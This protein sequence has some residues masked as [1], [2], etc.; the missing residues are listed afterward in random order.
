MKNNVIAFLCFA[1]CLSFFFACKQESPQTQPLPEGIEA[2]L[3]AYTSGTVS[4]T[5]PVEVRFVS[6]AIDETQVGQEAPE[7]VIEFTPKLTGKTIWKNRQT[8]VFTPDP[9]MKSG[10][11]YVAKVALDKVMDNLPA[12]LKSFE[13]DF[14]TKDQGFRVEAG[15]PELESEETDLS[16]QMIVGK[17]ETNDFAEPELVEQLLEAKQNGAALR[18]EWTHKDGTQHIFSIRGIQRGK[19]PSSVTLSWDGAPLGLSETGQRVIEIPKL[20]DFKISNATVVNEGGQYLL[21]HFTDPLLQNQDLRGLISLSDYDGNLDFVIDGNRLRVYPNAKLAGEKKVTAKPG[22]KNIKGEKM[23]KPSVWTLT[24]TEPEPGVRLVRSG[25]IMP[26]SKG[27]VLPFEAVNLNAVVVE[28]FKVFN[29]NIL[30][31][32]QDNDLDGHYDL[33][34]VGRVILQEKIDLAKLN[35]GASAKT[36]THYALD[37]EKLIQTDPDAIYQIR[38]GFKPEFST[39]EC[40][41]GSFIGESEVTFPKINE[42]GEIESFWGGW[43][44]INGPYD[45]YRWQDRDDPCKP[46]YYNYE[47]FVRQNI[48]SSNIG[49]TAKGGLDGSY[50]VAV[51]NLLNAQPMEGAEVRFYDYQQQ[52]LKSTKTDRY[53]IAQVELSRAPFVCVAEKGGDKGFLKMLDGNALSLSRFDVSG[54]VA[55]KGLKGFIYGDRGVWRP[56]DS[57]FLHFVLQDKT[58]KIPPNHPITF[59]L[60][61]PR[62]QVREKR[63]VTENKDF[64]YP[65]HVGTHSDDPTGNWIANISVGGAKFRKVVKIETIKPNRLKIDLDFGSEMLLAKNEPFPAE[66]QVNWLHGAPAK[67]LRAVVEAQIKTTRTRFKNYDQ[68]VFDDPA[69]QVGDEPFKIFEGNLDENG[70]ASFKTKI[71]HNPNV[72]PGKLKVA[73]NTRA[74]EK[75]GDFSTRYSEI[76]YSPFPQYV[77]IAVPKNK[78]N[79]PQIDIGKDADI[80][81][82][83][84]DA[85]GKPVRNKNISVGMY[86]V[87]WRWWYDRYEDNLTKFNNSNHFNAMKKAELTTNAKGEAVWSVSTTQWGRY[88]VRV[89]DLDGGHC[90]GSFFYAGYPWYDDNNQ[91]RREASMLQFAT[92]QSKYE[93]GQRI[94]INVPSSEKSRVLITLETGTKVIESRWEEAKKGDNTYTFEATPAM[95]PT[96]YA[97]VSLI[98]PHNQT[99]NDLPIR[100]YGVVPIEVSDPGTLLQPQIKMPDELQPEKQFTVEVSE[101]SGHDMTYTLAVVDEGLLDLTNFKTPNPHAAFY[102]REALGVKTWDIYDDVLGAYGGS[103]EKILSVGGDGAQKSN[104]DKKNANRFKPVV[105]HLG[106]FTLK[107][108]RKARHN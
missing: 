13:F 64:V 4:K 10:Q 85:A 32:M 47:R 2:W 98:Q 107:A 106:P 16:K 37:L 51:T 72:A 12:N 81:F 31:F 53:G 19:D 17:I 9:P 15:E 62:G 50:F 41:G 38:I 1:T 95:S 56:G 108:G 93:V 25:V 69:R 96:V 80:R 43:Y 84:L 33:N 44:G 58:G 49:I 20:G 78:Y 76:A 71:L 87:N 99:E 26:D 35:P 42:D 8:L 68:Y 65:L 11:V 59:E 46:A 73:F 7:G 66:L 92:D 22:I 74:F 100:M 102:A 27:L 14:R 40:N 61:D 77:G 55:Q 86:R 90:S 70:H 67:N 103:L 3:Y 5:G 94:K 54:S 18:I 88:M 28:V 57:L 83:V 6:A 34:K 24:F 63:M 89:C 97:H 23:L 39:Y 82:V 101:K 52:L 45:G 36:W 21:L 79:S 60:K 91:N 48:I 105:L 75:G 104:P 30:Q 29:N